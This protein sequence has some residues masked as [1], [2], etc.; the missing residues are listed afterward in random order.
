MANNDNNDLVLF[1][2]MAIFA[3]IFAA[4]FTLLNPDFMRYEV[5]LNAATG[6]PCYIKDYKTGEELPVTDELLEK[7]DGSFYC[8]PSLCE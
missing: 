2:I 3:I 7:A 8:D 5:A 6:K 1:L 4:G